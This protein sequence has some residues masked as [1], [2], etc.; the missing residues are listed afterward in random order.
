MIREFSNKPCIHGQMIFDKVTKTRVLIGKGQSFQQIV[1]GKLQ[2][3]EV[4]CYL[5]P[6][7]KSTQNRSKT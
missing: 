6:Y 5:I 2:K 1:L 4:D 7:K 3:N